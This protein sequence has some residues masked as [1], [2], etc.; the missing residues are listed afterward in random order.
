MP[1]MIRTMP[2]MTRAVR[3]VLGVVLAITSVLIGVFWTPTCMSPAYS[4]PTPLPGSQM[5][6]PAPPV[7][8]SGPGMTVRITIAVAG[9]C[10]GLTL[11]V[12]ALRPRREV[13]TA[14]T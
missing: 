6:C 13:V 12:L 9:T 5:T 2:A 3:V 10:L 14:G 4:C 1:S 8:C 7:Y 11:A